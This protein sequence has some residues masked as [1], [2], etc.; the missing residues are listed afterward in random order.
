MEF[1]QG[2]K[3]DDADVAARNAEQMEMLMKKKREREKQCTLPSARICEECDEEIPE[4][5][6]IAQPGC[7]LC[8]DCQDALERK[9]LK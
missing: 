4:G 1:L 9:E 8:I 6:R 3:M 2:F 7:R 5:R